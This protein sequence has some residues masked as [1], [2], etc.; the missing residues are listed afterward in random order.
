MTAVKNQACHAGSKLGVALIFSSPGGGLVENNTALDLGN[1]AY[2]NIKDKEGRIAFETPVKFL[3]NVQSG[4]Q[5][6]VTY[7]TELSE[8]DVLNM[9]AAGEGIVLYANYR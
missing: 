4:N 1:G 5:Q 9:G 8:K 7:Q 6:T 2:F 3:D